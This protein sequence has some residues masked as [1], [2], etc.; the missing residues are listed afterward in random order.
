[1]QDKTQRCRGPSF[2][3][4]QIGVFDKVE[5]ANLVENPNDALFVFSCL[6]F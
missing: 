4:V 6:Y 2:A 1:M 5:K 3:A